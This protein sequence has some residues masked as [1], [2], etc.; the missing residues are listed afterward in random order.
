MC[1]VLSPLHSGWTLCLG[2]STVLPYRTPLASL[3]FSTLWQL[4]DGTA[5][6]VDANGEPLSAEAREAVLLQQ[7]EQL[8]LLQQ[9]Q[10]QQQQQVRV[11]RPIWA[12]LLVPASDTG[13]IH[14]RA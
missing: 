12:L 6:L 11:A 14:G 10:L 2:D 4:L 13:A 3:P 8:M 5:T 7:Q 1:T 9:Q